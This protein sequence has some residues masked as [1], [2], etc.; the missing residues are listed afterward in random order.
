MTVLE[1]VVA[2]L[3]PPVGVWMKKGLNR[4]V[5]IALLLW[6]LGHIPGAIYALYVI[7]RPGA[8]VRVR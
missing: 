4:Q 6:L 3:L 8:D 2:L 5:F 1:I 7:S